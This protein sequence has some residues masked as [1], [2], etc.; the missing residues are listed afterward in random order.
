MKICITGTNRGL[1]LEFTRQ[2]LEL[3]NEVF[4]ACRNPLN[5]NSLQQLRNKYV[6]QLH[7]IPIDLSDPKSVI[8]AAQSVKNNTSS[9]D[10][11]INNAGM[12][13]SS[14]SPEQVGRFQK[15]DMLE[16]KPMTKIFQVNA[17][18]PILVSKAFHGLL[19]QSDNPRIIMITSVQGSIS[20]TS[21]GGMYGYGGSKAALN[22]MGRALAFELLQ[23][24]IVTVMIHPGWV[25]T[26]MGG[27]N[28]TLSP[29]E[30]V[31]SMIGL[32]SGFRKP[33]NGRFFNYN[34]KELEW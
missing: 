23:D 14:G 25:R 13:A 5:A 8:A 3:G 11:L 15:F 9:I 22:R 18:G 21:G 10:L 4:A 19:K 29:Q 24:G 7:I 20:H 34:G 30:S 16:M 2:Y 28:A 32:I 1:G 12:G 26:D 33:Q 27:P 17:M 31:S 6:D